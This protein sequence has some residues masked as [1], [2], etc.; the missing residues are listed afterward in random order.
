MHKPRERANEEGVRELNVAQPKEKKKNG[1]KEAG[2]R[3]NR[4]VTIDRAKNPIRARF[5]PG[6]G[7]G[8]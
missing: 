8:G 2:S 4:R 3:G 5:I 1:G 7:K 6:E